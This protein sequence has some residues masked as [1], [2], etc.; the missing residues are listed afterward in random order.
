MN[1]FLRIVD[2]LSRL[3]LAAVFIYAAWSK[4]QD[5][6]LFADAV[7]SYKVISG[8]GVSWVALVLPMLELV[9]GLALIATK[10]SRESSLILVGLLLVFLIGL[11]QAWARG[12]E[13]SCGCFGSEEQSLPLWVDILRDMGLLVPAVWVAM[14][15]N[16]WLLG[17]GP[18]M[19]NVEVGIEKAV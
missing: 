8:F 19:K 10:W 16:A 7:A 11:T 1:V 6:A 14:R 3:F 5:P 12:L 18:Y 4:V 17:K 9:A 13:I 2:G 15:P